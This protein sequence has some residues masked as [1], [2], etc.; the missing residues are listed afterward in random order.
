MSRGRQFYTVN[1]YSIKKDYMREMVDMR[2]T[3]QNRRRWMLEASDWGLRMRMRLRAQGKRSPRLWT[4]RWQEG[5]MKMV[6]GGKGFQ[7]SLMYVSKILGCD[8]IHTQFTRIQP[9]KF[10]YN[11]FS[12]IWALFQDPPEI[13]QRYLSSFIPTLQLQQC[14]RYKNEALA[15]ASHL[16]SH[17]NNLKRHKTAGAAM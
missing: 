7:Q 15:A 6:T 10:C 9:I 1:K 12:P 11:T 4:L 16:I 14:C 17:Q 5:G 13:R 8:I 3:C 2:R